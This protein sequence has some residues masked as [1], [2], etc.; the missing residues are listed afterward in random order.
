MRKGNYKTPQTLHHKAFSLVEAVTALIILA[1]V[2][3]SVLIVI[4]RCMASVADSQLRMQ[5]F[6]TAR[7]NMERLLASDSVK[8]MVEFGTSEKF[9]EIKWETTVETFYEPITARMWIRGVCSAQYTDTDGETQTVELEHWLTDVSKEQL[10]QILKEKQREQQLL[11]TRI[12]GTIQQAAEY[13]G[14]DEAT[15]E[16]WVENGMVT[17]EDGSFIADNLD[18]Y[19]QTN[20]NPTVEQMQ[21]QV[22][23]A[24]VMEQTRQ[25]EPQQSEPEQAPQDKPEDKPQDTG[26]RLP[27]QQELESMTFEEVLQ[28]VNEFFKQR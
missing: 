12:F 15:V 23:E 17:A 3:S 21:Q 7:E 1:I 27:T 18:L 2:S 28:F 13:A 9:P 11:G 6:E 10:L 20:G 26:P 4:N 19:E 24:E 25:T 22:T 8:E 14:V 5:A 16:Q